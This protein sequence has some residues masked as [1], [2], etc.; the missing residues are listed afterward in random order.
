[1]SLFKVVYNIILD[2]LFPRS[3]AELKSLSYSPEEAWNKLPRAPEPLL[4]DAFSIFAY[5]DERVS[6]LIWNIK[7]KNS[8]P[9]VAIGGYS[10]HKQFSEFL[11]KG[12]DASFSLSLRN[13]IIVPIPI[14]QRRKNER[15]YN[16]CELLVDEMKR[17][18]TDNKLTIRKDLLERIHHLSRQ[19]LK[20]RKDRLK[21][22]KGIF[23][24]NEKAAEE[25]ARG[26]FEFNNTF[27][28]IIDD[29]IT[30]GSTMK[31]AIATLKNAGFENVF[32]LSLAH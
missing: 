2:S 22:A 5:K 10:L 27:I 25:I 4:A 3:S 20:N 9:A 13:I 15:G 31:E 26:G 12:T 8:K 21:S 6:K 29:V 11:Q 32:G 24:V 17:L 19:T 7:Y 14:T 30:T 16:Q 18:D 23:I 28:V 1:M